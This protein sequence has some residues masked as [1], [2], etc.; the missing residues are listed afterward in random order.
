MTAGPGRGPTLQPDQV[1]RLR[2]ALVAADYLIDPAM[3]AIGAAG[4]ADLARNHTLAAER[5]LAGRDDA[6]ATLIRLFVLQ[7]AQ[8]RAAVARALPLAD[9]VQAGLLAEGADGVRALVDLRPYGGDD[10]VAGWLVSDHQATLNTAPARPRPDHVLGLSPAAV[11]LAQ[12]TPRSPVGSALDL[13]TGCGVQA[14]HLARHADVVT[15]TDL[16]PRALDLARLTFR[17]SEVN[18]DLV[19]GSLYE[20]VARERFDLIV[21]NPPFV[22]SPPNR[23]RLVYREANVPGDGLMRGVVAGAGDRLAPGG[24]LVVLGNWAHE[25]GVPWGERL[26]E[27]VPPG[28]DALFVQRELI[29]LYHYIEL[30]LADAGVCGTVQYRARYEEWLQYLRSQGIETLGLG[31]ILLEKTGRRRPTVT[32]LEWP[33]PTCPGLADDLA[34]HFAAGRA[35]RLQDADLLAGRWRLAEDAVQEAVGEPGAADPAVVVLRR[36]RGLGRFVQVDTALGGLL[37]ACDG[38]L[39]L[40]ALLAAVAEV[41]GEG[42]GELT[43]RLLPVVRDLIAATWLTLSSTPDRSVV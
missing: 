6:L 14:L 23:H 36:R 17:L 28:C 13:G 35:A 25:K 5:A 29:D 31:W 9:L 1:G 43:A 15:A 11:T 3:A 7:L 38:E 12:L 2:A 19:S 16:N 27:W 21:T 37:G 24:R 42:P 34:A 22:L 40:G 32:A 4:R 33:H 30:W 26:A 41:T 18:A 20:P 10:G 8:P 39:P